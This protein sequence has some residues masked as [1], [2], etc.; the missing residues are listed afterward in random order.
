MT[1]YFAYGA[2]MDPVHMA[3]CCP[4]A[5]RLG[6]ATL[7]DHAFDIAAG[8]FGTVRRVPGRVVVGVLWR[9]GPADLAAL[10]TFE[11]VAEDFYRRCGARV[12]APDGR[13]VD[14]M[15]YRPSNDA[16]GT[17]ASGYLERIVAVA[18]LLGFQ[19]RYI[20]ELQTLLQPPATTNSG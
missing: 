15:I 1:V 8:G 17:P 18:Q 4:G 10:D 14:A 6:Q 16:P 13:L 3:A 19:P 12:T 2:N 20:A 5:E 11:G 9:L 7:A